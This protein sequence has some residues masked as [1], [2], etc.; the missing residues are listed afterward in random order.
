MR[1]GSLFLC[2]QLPAHGV[3]TG[4]LL[5]RQR[6]V[7]IGKGRPDGPYG[8]K[9]RLHV[10]T[11]GR[12]PVGRRCRQRA[13]TRRLDLVGC[14]GAGGG[15]S[16]QLGALRRIR[17]HDVVDLVGRKRHYAFGTGDSR[18]LHV[19]LPCPLS[20]FLRLGACVADIVEPRLLL[21]GQ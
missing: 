7:E 4:L 9:H 10:A 12:E 18:A 8:G 11:L 13:R 2:K 14:L 19:A 1:D 20:L 6:P 5:V 16:V 15:E 3:E 21:V 17:L